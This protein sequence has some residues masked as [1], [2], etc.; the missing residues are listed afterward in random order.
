MCKTQKLEGERILFL[1]SRS[2]QSS[3]KHIANNH[4]AMSYLVWGTLAQVSRKSRAE[5]LLDL[6][7]KGSIEVSQV[8]SMTGREECMQ[9]RE[10]PKQG[11]FKYLPSN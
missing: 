8:V 1:I 10:A 2:L 9:G 5:I 4:S 3:C 11:R 7:L 6:R